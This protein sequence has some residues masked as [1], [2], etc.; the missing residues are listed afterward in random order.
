MTVATS[1]AY[2]GSPAAST[3]Q[4]NY[5]TNDTVGTAF[6]LA[7]TGVGWMVRTNHLH[8]APGT[9]L[10]NQFRGA[11]RYVSDTE[12]DAVRF[13]L[14]ESAD[15]VTAVPVTLGN[16][17]QYIDL[18]ADKGDDTLHIME[19]DLG[20]VSVTLEAGKF[21][22]FGVA[23]RGTAG[24][25]TNRPQAYALADTEG[26]QGDQF[27]A[28]TATADFPVS[29]FS[30][31]DA[32]SAREAFKFALK[33]KTNNRIVF[34][35]AYSAAAVIS[36]PKRVDG[37]Y[38]I[39]WEDAVVED[40]QAFTCALDIEDG[41]VQVTRNTLVLDF[42][43]TDQITFGGANVALNAVTPE[44]GDTFDLAARYTPTANTSD[45]F[46]QNKSTPQGVS[47]LDVITASHAVKNAGTRG[48]EYTVTNP[49]D[50][51]DMSGTAT[52]AK[53]QIGWEP[54]VIFGDSQAIDGPT[55]F[56]GVLPGA[57]TF[58]RIVWHAGISSSRVQADIASVI[59]GYRRY[60]HETPGSG[61]LCE[62]KGIVFV[63]AGYGVNDINQIGDTA[64]NRNV[65]M[66][67][68]LYRV[69]EILGDV[70]QTGNQILVIGLPPYS[71]AGGATD[72]EAQT[73]LHQL[74]PALEGIAIGLRAAYVNPWHAMCQAGTAWAAIPTFFG[75]YT[76]DAGAHYSEAGITIVAQ[77][78]VRS[79]E[80]AIIGGWWANPARR[81]ARE[82]GLLLP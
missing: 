53:I 13:V 29:G 5:V 28:S 52:V 16:G 49:P 61:D 76:L 62:M 6:G 34:E 9:Y 56:G 19:A 44:A 24:R 32:A 7:G 73:I 25:T 37:S 33:I 2:D 75:D 69:T 43:A 82:R 17:L 3:W 38:W 57:F 45:L 12:C 10:L 78:A 23:L 40:G 35:T 65:L 80:T 47:N 66:G 59:A 20:D 51:L 11:V 63:W 58:P 21:Y 72:D 71:K 50:M 67:K 41:G 30:Y 60:K 14:L 74:N 36:V 79:L 22:Y 77:A 39:K 54:V 8:L 4:I 46:W 31:F 68:L 15:H 42:G 70:A 1:P 64:A 27:Y 48:A 81:Y 18:T 26:P 55:Q